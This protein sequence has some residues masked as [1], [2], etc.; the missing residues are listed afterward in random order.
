MALFPS[1][2]WLKSLVDKLNT[3]EKYAQAAKNWEGDMAFIIEPGG[4]LAETQ[5][6]YL[7]LWHGKC[8]EGFVVD[9]SRE[10]KPVFTLKGPYE[11]YVRLLR[12]E[13][14]PM[15]ALL[16]RKIGVQGNMAILMRSVPTVLDF[17][18]CCREV[19]DTFLD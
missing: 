18:R 19:T 3:D 12:G 15:Q 7:D 5:N 17:V 16:T 14:E 1:E 10:V 8:R 6:Y 13:I 11:N 9:G 4:P 2:D